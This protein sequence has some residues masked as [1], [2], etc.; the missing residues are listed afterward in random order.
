MIGSTGGG[1]AS[2]GG[3]VMSVCGEMHIILRSHGLHGDGSNEA[4]VR[5]YDHACLRYLD[6]VAKLCLATSNMREV[7]HPDYDH[8]MPKVSVDKVGDL[9]TEWPAA[10]DGRPGLC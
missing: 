9:G 3:E 5:P 2:S 8:D 1:E 7:A 4:V 6:S 10:D